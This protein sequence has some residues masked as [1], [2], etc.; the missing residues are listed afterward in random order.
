M[1]AKGS[2][3]GRVGAVAVAVLAASAYVLPAAGASPADSTLPTAKVDCVAFDTSGKCVVLGVVYAMTQVGG[4]TYIGGSFTSVNKEPRA[5]V[6][7][8]LGDGTLDPS[9][10]PS[11]DGT[12]YAMAASADGSKIY[13]GGGFT[14][15]NGAPQG[16][17]A[18]VTSDTG[19]LV[20][21]WS[22]TPSNNLVRALV[23]DEQD[24]LFVGG[25]FSRIGGRAIARLAAVSQST[26]A[27][28][29]GFVPAPSNTVRA[30]ALSDD[31]T[32][33]YA[34]GS[35][36]A[37]GGASRPGAGELDATSGRA[38]SFAPTD[39]GVVIAMDVSSSG[40]LFFGTT[41]NRTWAYDVAD[42]GVPEYR[43]RTAGDVQAIL[44]LDDEVFIGGHFDTLPEAKLERMALASF[45]PS[46]GTATAWNPGANGPYGVWAIGL[47][48][49]G[50]S[51]DQAPAL[52][53]G[54]D[55]TRVGTQA[56]RGYARF[57]FPG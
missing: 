26:G 3:A 2:L 10:R 38:T 17:L 23:A 18:A 27:V 13:L 7:A 33:L 44:A 40:R 28:D 42:G 54:G 29:A 39:G 46:D 35:F 50:L 37:I 48:R 43:V 21:G 36:T 1:R 56:R 16:R 31:G 24:R 8:V 15:V 12:V 57:A 9:W 5:N 49:T 53:I 6:A 20:P 45:R 34:G 32:R 11:T 47:T 51:A 52:S 4:R 22:G 19:S 30:L 14:T 25:N 41:S 55:F